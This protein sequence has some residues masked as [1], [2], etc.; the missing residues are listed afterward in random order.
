LVEFLACLAELE[1]RRLHLDLGFASTF[2]FCT[3]HL[4]L[5]KGSAFRRTTA[6][7][8]LGRFPIVADYLADGRLN[9][10]TLVELREVLSEKHLTEIL[11]RAAGRGEEEV[12]MLVAA[13]RPQPEPPDLLRRLPTVS[14][15]RPAS[16]SGPNQLE[17][18][19]SAPTLALP[20]VAP[21]PRE[22]PPVQVTPIAE[23]RYVV[24]ASVGREFV[25]DLKT[26]RALLSHKIPDGDLEQVLHEC[27]RIAAAVLTKKR[28]GAGKPSGTAPAGP[29]EASHERPPTRHVPAAVRDEVWRRDDS[30]CAYV[31][32]SGRRCNSTWQLELHHLTPFAKG[33]GSTVADLELRCRRHN[34]RAAELDFGLERMAR[35]RRPR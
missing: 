17:P 24:R 18:S 13:L 19:V 29:L 31:A 7:R 8:L 21:A 26:V 30:R 20:A 22:H 9:L 16:G 28:R 14:L 15:A 25:D 32:P 6:A 10:T 1:R 33:G 5:T 27:L 4:G 34:Q 23:E 12:K 3:D 35:A 11:D 2:A